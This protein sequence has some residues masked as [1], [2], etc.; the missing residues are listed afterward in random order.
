MTDSRVLNRTFRRRK[1][2]SAESCRWGWPGGYIDR[3]WRT[4]EN[5]TRKS[6]SSRD[7]ADTARE[8]EGPDGE[9][10]GSAAGASWDRWVG[11]DFRPM[12]SASGA[13]YPRIQEAC[14][15]WQV[16]SRLRSLR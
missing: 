3:L 8:R 13:A 6:P 7:K 4:M 16:L 11:R 14:Q 5:S 1:N 15:R 10:V 12:T 9:D 2:R